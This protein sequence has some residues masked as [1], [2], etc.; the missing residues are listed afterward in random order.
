MKN[1]I[2]TSMHHSEKTEIK[3]FSRFCGM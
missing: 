1:N 2:F 3:V